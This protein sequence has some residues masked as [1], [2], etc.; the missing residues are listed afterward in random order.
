M[1][2]C[3]KLHLY[4]KEVLANRNTT[5]NVEVDR[6]PKMYILGV[7]ISKNMDR[8]IKVAI[9]RGLYVARKQISKPCISV[10]PPIAAGCMKALDKYNLHVWHV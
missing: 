3:Q 9:M 5:Y 7:D 6:D 2:K 4:L 10:E 1:W 8:E